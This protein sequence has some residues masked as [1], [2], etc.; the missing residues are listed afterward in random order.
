M[1]RGRPPKSH[2]INGHLMT[3]ANTRPSAWGRECK[4]C[5]SARDR[6]RYE[7]NPERRR[8]VLENVAAFRARNRIIP[9]RSLPPASE[10][11]K[12][13]ATQS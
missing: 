11:L 13:G 4:L 10:W 8:Q 7:N 1:A 6:L 2:C 5:R 12:L 9:A 3:D